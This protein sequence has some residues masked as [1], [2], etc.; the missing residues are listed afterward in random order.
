MEKETTTD[1]EERNSNIYFKNLYSI[2][3]EI[4][5]EMD[6]FLL[7][8]GQLKLNWDEVNKLNITITFNEIEAVV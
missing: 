5:K 8:D 6:G 3:L 4:L 7:V 1:T 2:N